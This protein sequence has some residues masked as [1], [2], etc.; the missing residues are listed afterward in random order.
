MKHN[1]LV[2]SVVLI[3][4][5]SACAP[6]AAPTMSAADVAATAQAA[7][8][9]MVVQTQQAMPTNTPMPTETASP[10]P[11]V[12]DTPPSLP[13][14]SIADTGLPGIQL[15]T[16]QPTFTPQSLSNSGSTPSSCNQPLT[17]WQ[18]TTAQF[19]ISN[20][21]KPKGTIVLSLYVETE[22]GQCGYLIITGDSFTGPAG[23]YQAGAFIT[24]KKNMKA[25][26]SFKISGGRWK[27]VITNNNITA[28]GSCYPDC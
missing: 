22:M 12:T 10:A 8:L 4:L 9:T 19:T 27:I 23:Q 13:T 20:Q 16:A 11:L 17:K 5:A 6:K 21:T 2:I 15:P 3:L 7:A 14:I 18:G 24:G 1:V 28:A 26:G 25:F